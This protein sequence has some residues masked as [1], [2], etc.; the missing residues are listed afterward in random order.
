MTEQDIT[1]VFTVTAPQPDM[2]RLRIRTDMTEADK[3]DGPLYADVYAGR[4]WIDI[5]S[6]RLATSPA[7]TFARALLGETEKTP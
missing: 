3:V 5:P 6:D 4:V 2:V 7:I 1:D